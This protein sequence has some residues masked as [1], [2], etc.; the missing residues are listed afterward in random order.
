[1]RKILTGCLSEICSSA[2]EKIDLSGVCKIIIIG[3]NWKWVGQW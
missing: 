1:M 2:K 3:G